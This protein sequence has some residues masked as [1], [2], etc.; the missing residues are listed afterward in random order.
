MFKYTK[1]SEVIPQKNMKMKIIMHWQKTQNIVTDLI[2]DTEN[3]VRQL[4]PKILNTFRYMAPTK[5]NNDKHTP[6]PTQKMPIQP[7]PDQKHPTKK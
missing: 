2:I 5:I 3:A 1:S 7:Q 6:H 4:D